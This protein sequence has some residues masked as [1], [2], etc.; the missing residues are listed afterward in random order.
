MIWDIFVFILNYFCLFTSS[1]KTKKNP[2]SVHIPGFFFL[3]YIL[4]FI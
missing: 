4:K 2:L 1:L 3:G